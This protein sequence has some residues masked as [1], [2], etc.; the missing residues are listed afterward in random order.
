MEPETQKLDWLV[1]L[2]FQ[3]KEKKKIRAKIQDS[4]AALSSEKFRKIRAEIWCSNPEIRKIPVLGFGP[5]L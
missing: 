2:K 5:T 1:C 3:G 4:F